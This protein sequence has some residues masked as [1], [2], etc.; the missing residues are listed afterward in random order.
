LAE[1]HFLAVL[2]TGGAG[3]IGSNLVREL[4]ALGERVVVFD[5][6]S[7]GSEGNLEGIGGQVELVVGDVRNASAVRRAAHGARAVFH[8][9]ALGSVE[10][11]IGDPFTS[12]AVNVDGTLNVLVAAREEGAKRVVYASSSSVYGDTPTL[13]KHEDMPVSTLSPYAASKL[14]GES[15]CRAFYRSYELGTV[16][17]RFFNVFGPRQDPESRYA[18]VIPRFITAIN[19]GRAP[20]IYGDG[21]QSRDFT[22]IENVV[23]AI[24]Q[25]ASASGPA[26]GEAMN[27]ACGGRISLLELLDELNTVMGTNAQPV[28]RPRRRGDVAHSEA[29]IEKARRLIGYAPAT[30]FSEGLAATA[31]WFTPHQTTPMVA[32]S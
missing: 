20:E 14:A 12:H 2:V 31:R 5:D 17:L 15:Y 10:R 29:S 4:A 1:E 18:A 9:A 19:D 30:T 6:L 11:S 22:Y 25:A 21:H 23:Q 7:T 26:L 3:F 28:F 16:C 27:V 8:L 32:T 13:P 24:I